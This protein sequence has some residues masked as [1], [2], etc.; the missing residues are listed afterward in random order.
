MHRAGWR[1]HRL[2]ESQGTLV[3][4]IR[5]ASP[6]SI[7]LGEK[8]GERKKK[9]GGRKKERERRLG[10]YNC[11]TSAITVSA[12]CPRSRPPIVAAKERTVASSVSLLPPPPFRPLPQLPLPSRASPPTVSPTPVSR[13]GLDSRAR[14]IRASLLRLRRRPRALSRTFPAIQC[15]RTR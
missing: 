9:N 11:R 7:S 6:K 13:V 8:K 2:R 12:L 14:L 3:P 4:R 5:T 1:R 15:P 10:T